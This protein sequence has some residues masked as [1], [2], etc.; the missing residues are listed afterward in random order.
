MREKLRI[1]LGY[2]IGQKKS[3]DIWIMSGDYFFSTGLAL[4]GV[5][6]TGEFPKVFVHQGYFSNEN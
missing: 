1:W 3:P 6:G 4:I 5:I 2:A